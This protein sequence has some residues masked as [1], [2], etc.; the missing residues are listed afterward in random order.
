MFYDSVEEILDGKESNG[1]NATARG[2][3]L[4]ADQLRIKISKRTLTL[5]ECLGIVRES[6][7]PELLAWVLK[8]IRPKVMDSINR[9][10]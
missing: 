6:E 10:N 1:W 2:L 4:T 3:N 8:E 7:S 9:P 5:D